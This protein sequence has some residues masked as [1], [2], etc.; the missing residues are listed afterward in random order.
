MSKLSIHTS[1]LA[2]DPGQTGALVVVDWPWTSPGIKPGPRIRTAL[3]M[4][5]VTVNKKKALDI[6]AVLEWLPVISS[7]DVGIIEHVHSMPKQGVASSFQFGRMFG[8]AETVIYLIDKVRYVSPRV[9]KRALNLSSD[10]YASID[11]A[12]RIFGRNAAQRWFSLKKN[13]GTAEAALIAYWCYEQR[14]K[15]E[16]ER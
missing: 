10:K 7:I 6:A 9:W 11:L 14:V 8:A 5:L 16:R 13:E 12:T 4:P 1:I 3:P 15:S 2:I